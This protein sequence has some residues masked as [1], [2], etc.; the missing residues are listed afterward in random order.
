LV[1]DPAKRANQALKQRKNSH[2][3]LRDK[4]QARRIQVRFLS[5]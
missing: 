3:L 4:P 2:Y 5:F 1:L